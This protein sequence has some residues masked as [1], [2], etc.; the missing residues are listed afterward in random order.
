MILHF[1]VLCVS[2]ILLL[3][4]LPVPLDLASSAPLIWLAMSKDLHSAEYITTRQLCNHSH[5]IHLTMQI[6]LLHLNN[7]KQLHWEQPLLYNAFRRLAN[8]PLSSSKHLLM[9]SHALRLSLSAGWPRLQI[10]QIIMS[11]K[12]HLISGSIK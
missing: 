7:T 5:N 9:I 3:T 6:I 11:Q 10:S 4:W 1:N 8:I 12:S 2:Y